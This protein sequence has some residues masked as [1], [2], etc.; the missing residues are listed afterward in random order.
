MVPDAVRKCRNAGV[1]MVLVTGGKTLITVDVLFIS[2]EVNYSFLLLDHPTTAMA[3]GR[4]VG[5]V[6]EGAETIQEICE[7][8]QLSP[9]QISPSRVNVVVVTGSELKRMSNE[10]L[11][12]IITSNQELVFAR[13]TPEQKFRIVEAFQKLGHFVG[14]EIIQ[15][16]S[17]LLKF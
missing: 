9:D 4:V 11:N 14:N 10:Q 15:D 8:K 17:N 5:I 12:S 3:I 1:R 13:T 16:W 7:R 6:S 2:F